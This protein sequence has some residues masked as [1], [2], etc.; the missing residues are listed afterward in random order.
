MNMGLKTWVFTQADQQRYLYEQPM[1]YPVA[2]LENARDNNDL[3]EADREEIRKIIDDYN[4]A[5]EKNAKIDVVAS[6]RQS[7]AA[8][9][10]ALIIVGLPL[11]LY[12][13]IVIRRDKS[14][15]GM[16]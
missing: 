11:Y 13:W 3:T 6:Q 12:H 7:D 15:V 8:Q 9:N 1:V 5:K 16:K 2:K 4:A 10:L 14:V